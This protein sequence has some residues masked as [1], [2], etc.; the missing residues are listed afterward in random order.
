[1]WQVASLVGLYMT[2]DESI[3]KAAR[4][5]WLR[6]ELDG[7]E[8]LTDRTPVMERRRSR[9][10]TPGSTPGNSL[11]GGNLFANGAPRSLV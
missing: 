10:R 5:R 3:I 11:H 6:S 7:S 4:K 1:M 2:G 8:Q 9:V